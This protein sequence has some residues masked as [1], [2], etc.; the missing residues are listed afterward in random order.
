MRY[1]IGITAVYQ[2]GL[3]SGMA[4]KMIEMKEPW[5]WSIWRFLVS[6]W[7]WIRESV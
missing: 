3:E 7:R 6:I 1:K 2:D 4:V 5:Y